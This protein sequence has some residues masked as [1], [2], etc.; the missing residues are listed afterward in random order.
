MLKL[1]DYQWL[2]DLDAGQ[3]DRTIKMGETLY[4]LIM[5]ALAILLD[6]DVWLWD[7]EDPT[8][9]QEE[10]IRMLMAYVFW[11]MVMYT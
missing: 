7:G 4:N 3:P 11:Y 9:E 10:T 8:D 6:A 5:C 2:I 1:F